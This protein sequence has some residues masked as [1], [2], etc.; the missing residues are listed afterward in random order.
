MANVIITGK[1]SIDEL[2]RV[3]AIEKLKALS[4]EELE[5]L[6]SLSDN[7]K[8]RAYLSSATKFTMLKTFL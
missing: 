8:A 3:K 6:T 1:N 7:S 5:R 4:T 2:K